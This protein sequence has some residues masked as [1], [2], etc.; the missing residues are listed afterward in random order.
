MISLLQLRKDKDLTMDQMADIIDTTRQTYSR[1]ERGE[2]DLSLGQAVRLTQHFDMNID[3][4][5]ATDVTSEIIEPTTLDRNKYG[6]IIQQFI[7][8]GTEY[9]KITKTKLA[10]LC[11]LLDFAWYYEHGESITGLQYRRIQQ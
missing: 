4:F 10:K 7:K 6:Q 11:Y 9:N 8:Q 2:S 5:I 1:I 3:Q